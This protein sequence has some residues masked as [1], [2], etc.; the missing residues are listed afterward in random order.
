MWTDGGAGH[1]PTGDGL[2][3]EIERF[4]APRELPPIGD[5]VVCGAK[6]GI[7]GSALAACL[8]ST[9]YSING[10]DA[11][12]PARI[13]AYFILG[14]ASI[15]AGIVGVGLG[16]I[17]CLAVGAVFGALFGVVMAKFVGK[18]GLFMAAGVGAIYGVLV[19][20]VTQY[21]LLIYLAP[22]ALILY[23]QH[24]LL[25]ASVAY[26]LSLGSFGNAYHV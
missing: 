18:V 25:W 8:L 15:A 17:I 13:L 26:G 20:I 21:V 14:N 7:V 19:W 5:A 16:I 2:S 11:I 22:G 6:A 3:S 4:I 24:A 23:D 1:M 10:G 12:L 9:F